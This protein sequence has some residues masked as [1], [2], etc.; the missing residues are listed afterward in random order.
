LQEGKLLEYGNALEVL[1][2]PQ[3]KETKQFID[4]YSL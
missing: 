2:T 1:S 4:F 3:K